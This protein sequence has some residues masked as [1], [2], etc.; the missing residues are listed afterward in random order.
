GAALIGG[1]AGTALASSSK[2]PVKIEFWNP[3]T[4]VL[5]SKIISDLVKAF[6]DGPG[7]RAGILVDN[8]IVPDA[9]SAVKYTTAMTA[10]SGSPDV[11]MTYSYWPIISWA[12]NGFIQHMDAYA[13]KLGINQKDYFP[14]AWDMINVNGHI[15]GLMQEF[16][17]YELAWNKAIHAGPPPKT[18]AEL[19][20]LSKR[21]TVFDKKGNLVQAGIVPWIQGGYG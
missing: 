10:S 11:V 4:D 17:F 18:I 19:D 3:A 12:A 15:W 8:R 20:A 2:A 16:D 13:K 9:N 1:G 5:G 7:K 6:N 21:Y 14:I